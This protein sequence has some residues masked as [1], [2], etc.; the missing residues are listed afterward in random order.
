[1]LVLSI[2]GGIHALVT[3]KSKAFAAPE[4]ETPKTDDRVL[5][6]V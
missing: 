5:A 3:P 2:A 1:M 6:Y 4:A